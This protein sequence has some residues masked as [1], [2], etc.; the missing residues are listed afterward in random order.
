MYVIFI[1]QG[2]PGPMGPQGIMGSVGP[3]V[4][5][6]S[7]DLRIVFHLELEQNQKIYFQYIHSSQNV[8][9]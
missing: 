9:V 8:P 4:S 6:N 5:T 7:H 2:P 3:P 1:L